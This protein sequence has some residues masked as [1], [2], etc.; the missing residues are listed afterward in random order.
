[1]FAQFSLVG[2]GCPCWSYFLCR[3]EDKNRLARCDKVNDPKHATPTSAGHV[4]PALDGMSA[5]GLVPFVGLYSL[6]VGAAALAT[7]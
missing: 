2:K 7:K 6:A 4:L 1:M 5:Q 3:C